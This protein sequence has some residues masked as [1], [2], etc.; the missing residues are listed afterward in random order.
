M[1]LA[2]FSTPL[3]EN[4]FHFV[5]YRLCC[6]IA[7]QSPLSVTQMRRLY[8]IT[9]LYSASSTGAP[10]QS[11]VPS[12]IMEISMLFIPSYAAAEGLRKLTLDVIFSENKKCSSQLPK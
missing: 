11:I 3:A 7:Q 10:P 1:T 8:V 6:E 9:L 12:K 5:C 2:Q 4:S